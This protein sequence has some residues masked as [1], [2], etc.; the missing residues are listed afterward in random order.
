MHDV[1]TIRAR[2]A[3][4]ARRYRQRHARA[5]RAEYATLRPS[6]EL[7]E[8]VLLRCA[9]T[10]SGCLVYPETLPNGYGFTHV[11]RVAV[12]THRLVWLA[13]RGPI[14]AGLELDHVRTRG[15]TSRA[16]CNVEHLEPVEHREN[17]LR[18]DGLCAVNARKKACV[19]G[20]PFDSRNTYTRFRLGTWRRECRTCRNA[21]AGRKRPR[22][23]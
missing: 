4:K 18:G 20:H 6:R 22:V 14:P 17:V 23:A 5:I 8:Q 3:E 1:A 13:L 11:G 7:A 16:C 21:A 9:A 19:H 12:L 15:C 2:N 10:A